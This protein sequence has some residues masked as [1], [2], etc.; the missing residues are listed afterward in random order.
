MKREALFDA[1]GQLPEELIA[2][3]AQK[4]MPKKLR[5]AP[6]AALAACL[7]LA[8]LLPF[9]VGSSLKASNKAEA[10]M[11]N[12]ALQDGITVDHSYGGTEQKAEAAQ[13]LARVV[14]VYEAHLM[15]EPLEDQWER[16]S[17]D[18][19]EVRLPNPQEFAVGDLV[20]ITYGGTLLE[21]Y[22]ARAVDVTEIERLG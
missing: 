1:I 20:R 14:E 12:A 6:M 21:S 15:V 5:W 13:F 7:C 19:I 10:P 17:S 18:R 3:A 2:E 16:N 9:A 22:P 11:E 8:L 4:R